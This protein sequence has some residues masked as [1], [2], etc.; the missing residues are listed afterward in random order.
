MAAADE[1]EMTA[2]LSLEGRPEAA[3]V[4]AVWKDQWQ[5][6]QLRPLMPLMPFIRDATWNDHRRFTGSIR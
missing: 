5:L 1:A 6:M 2:G 4:I 3:E